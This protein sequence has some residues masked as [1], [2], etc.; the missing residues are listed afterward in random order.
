MFDNWIN[1]DLIY[2]ND[3][4]NEN[5]EINQNLILDKLKYKNNWISEFICL[6]KA[7]PNEWY[8]TLQAQNAIKS[9]VN[10]QKDKIIVNGK[11]IDPSQL[12]NKYFYNEYI[13]VNFLKP[14][15]MNTW[16]MYLS[17]NEKPNMSQLYSFIFPFLEEN[18]LKIFRWKLLQYII[19]TK[20]LLMKWR[21]AINSQCNFCGKDEDYLH[22]FISCPYLKKIWVKIQQILKKS[23]IENCVTLKHI[24]FGY[25]IFDKIILI[26]T[27]F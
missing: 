23:N 8:H 5:G 1:S 17:I 2:I 18:K 27:I 9:V 20:K 19:P 21:I 24:V 10:F 12:S 4:L 14:I 7:I 3:F 15:G 22:Y 13:N 26:S 25:K 11:C 16:L 6:R